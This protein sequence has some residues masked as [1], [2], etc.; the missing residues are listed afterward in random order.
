[1]L[2]IRRMSS[3]PGRGLPGLWLAG[4]TLLCLVAARA[5]A[6][7]GAARTAESFHIRR[8]TSEDGLPATAVTALAQTPDGYLWAG[9]RF[10]LARFNGVR[11]TVFNRHNT[12]A[13]ASESINAL[14]VDQEGAL[15]IGTV[16]G[17]LR[18]QDRSFTR[19]GK[20]EGVP[21]EKVWT[22]MPSRL[23]GVWLH[24]GEGNSEQIALWSQESPTVSVRWSSGPLQRFR[25]F[26]END[27]GSLI[28]VTGGGF[29]QVTRNGEIS[30]QP[31]PAGSPRPLW[32]RAWWQR[33]RERLWISTAEGLWRYS[34]GAWQQAQSSACHTDSG[35]HMFEDRAGR[36]WINRGAAGLWRCDGERI[37][38]V[39][40][41]ETGAEPGVSGMIQDI[42][43]HLWISSSRG[44]FQLR[45]KFL[46]TYSVDQ[47]L[48]DRRCWSVAE[49]PDGAV[50]VET[51]RGV[52]RIQDERVQ[53]FPD[54]PHRQHTH[55][56]LVDRE[57][58]VW[59]GNKHD[60]VFAWRRRRETNSFW[61]EPGPDFT[62]G[63]NLNA[64]Y[65]DRA[66]RVWVGMDRGPVWF[67][68]DKP[69]A[70]FGEHGL[71]TNNV[72][73]IYQTR[74]GEMWFGTWM[75]GVIQWTRSADFSRL[76]HLLDK[77]DSKRIE[78]RAPK[79]A[80]VTRYT[81]ADGLADDRVFVFHE[82][83]DGALWIGTHNGLSRFKDGRFFTFRTEHGLFDNLINWL[84]EDD[85][86]RL[87]FS[88][89]RGIFRIDRT[90]M[91]DV[92][93]GRKPRA[94]AVVYGTADG[95]LSPESNGEHAPAGCKTRDGRIWFPTADGAVVIDPS[96]VRTADVAPVVVIEQVRADG[97][98][99]FGDGSSRREEAHVEKKHLGD[100]PAKRASLPRLLRL[101]PGRARDLQIRYT[102]NS[103]LDPNRT[104]FQYRLINHDA[105]W[106][107]ETAESLAVYTNLRPGDY[108]F[109]LRAAN[110]RGVWSAAPAVFSFSLAP[111]FWQTWPFYALCGFAVIGLAAGFTAYRLHWQ[112][113][114]LSA[115]HKQ[116]LAEERARIARDLHD[117]LGTALTG[118]A[119]ELD[120]ARQQS[121]DGIGVRLAEG[122]GRIRALAER[123]R[124]VVWAV[125]PHCDTVSS[126]A[127]FLEQQAGTLLQA[128]GVRGRF[129][130]PEDIPTLPLDSETR[131]QLALAVREALTNV[132][133]HAQ[134]AE[135]VL[136][137]ALREDAFVVRVQ[138]NGCGFD[139]HVV[140]SHAGH[141][142][143]NL[144]TRLAKLGGTMHIASKLG[145]GTRVEFR[146]PLPG[147]PPQKETK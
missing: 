79:G 142:L 52:A 13:M 15:W 44:L 36:V 140:T 94:D 97:E 2:A 72:R 70:K 17:L 11:F 20:A 68:N 77:S 33:N 49:A 145:A 138:D 108:R 66:H 38:A 29:Q 113:R 133:R 1:M 106:R 119:L 126:L 139:T 75:A 134:A 115:R 99:I 37:E 23:S 24:V 110:A 130:F 43:G 128:G 127:S 3:H 146:V 104:R 135:V 136:G 107:E 100:E 74:D 4:A 120:V 90:E 141:G 129:E 144:N 16:D 105:G 32:C 54:E 137:L 73:S 96:L 87:W 143:H 92:A 55:S 10:G 48:P 131:H 109:E 50:W 34:R 71:P 123:M 111:H 40:L 80:S 26:H 21:H 81:I 86:G 132:L 91:N 93:E 122:A 124:E 28:V 7:E 31:L 88:C 30:E 63:V 8:W 101:P 64:L 78:V 147:T 6:G 83:A 117:D 60:G 85:F 25:S 45:S 76:P 51:E 22:V 82:D 125:N 89:N 61:L 95:M 103:F 112:H 118:V 98:V 35:H 67:E 5:A 56:I 116:A 53:T 9:T 102:A 27:D 19:F 58:R 84:E 42:E 39:P 46:R 69:A 121:R 65:L 57:D 59:L 14:A 12:R 18:H 62:S 47:G 114:L 41:D